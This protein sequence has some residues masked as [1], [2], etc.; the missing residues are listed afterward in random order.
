MPKVSVIVPVYNTEKYLKK[1]IESLIN[2]TLQDIQIIAIDDGSTDN[3]G[4]ILD[5]FYRNYPEKLIVKHKTNGGQASARN[6]AI[7]FCTGEYIGFLDSDDYVENKM[8]EKLYSAA[9]SSNADYV[10]CGYRDLLDTGTEVKVLRDYVGNRPCRSNREMYLNG[11]KVSPFINFYKRELIQ[12]HSIFFTEGMIYEDTAFWAK[13]VPYIRK[14]IYIEESLANR[15]R[16]DNSTTTIVKPEKVRNIFSVI[17]DIVDF[18]QRQE[19][20]ADYHDEIEYFCSRVLLCSSMKRVS[21]VVNRADRRLL[22]NETFD[23]L[24]SLFPNYK[25]NKY[26]VDTNV[27]RYIK[28]TNKFLCNCFIFVMRIRGKK[29]D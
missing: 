26:L 12:E 19:L 21:R 18:Y 23:H 24:Q 8:F 10:G 28:S 1:C 16:H 7:G 25:K 29:Y 27:N 22:V 6:L 5:E 14:P 17:E 4:N 2:Q 15:V 3:S 13:I 9:V 11:A 20:L